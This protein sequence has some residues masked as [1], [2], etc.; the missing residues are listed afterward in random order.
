MSQGVGR[1]GRMFRSLTEVL[2]PGSCPGCGRPAEPVCASC[3]STMRAPTP[4]ATPPGL[5]DLG[6]AFVYDGVARELVAR[7]KYRNTRGGVAW[8]ADAMLAAHARQRIPQRRRRHLGADHSGPPTRAR[9]RSRRAARARGRPASEDF[10]CAGSSPARRV[11]RRP[12]PVG[13]PGWPARGSGP[14]RTAAG[15][16]ILIVDDVVTTGATLTAGAVALRRAGA[17]ARAR[18]HRSPH[19]LSERA[20]IAG[21]TLTSGIDHGE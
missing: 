11:L 4:F 13:R 1:F 20:L 10:P 15:R 6:V 9:L 21:S 8:L 3:A 18:A 19:S 16:R 12:G 14:G 5:D 2:L 17:T 7:I